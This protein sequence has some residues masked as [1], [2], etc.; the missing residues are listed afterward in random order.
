MIYCPKQVS[1]REHFAF[2]I[3]HSCFYKNTKYLYYVGSELLILVSLGERILSDTKLNL[4]NAKNEFCSRLCAL[5]AVLGI[6]SSGF[7]YQVY[8]LQARWPKA[9]YFLQVS[10]CTLVKWGQNPVTG[11][12]KGWKRWY[13]MKHVMWFLAYAGWGTFCIL[14]G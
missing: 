5:G 10:V 8:H 2:L 4:G 9:N 13:I 1:W 6:R 7:K 14:R 3:N 11:L 12:S